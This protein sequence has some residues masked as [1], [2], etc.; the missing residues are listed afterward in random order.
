MPGQAQPWQRS[1]QQWCEREEALKE[2]QRLAQVG[3]GAGRERGA[4]CERGV[5]VKGVR[6]GWE[7]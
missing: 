7:A 2:Q 1:G 3:R 4:W 5:G 6:G